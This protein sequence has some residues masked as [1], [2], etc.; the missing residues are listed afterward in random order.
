MNRKIIITILIIAMVLVTAA[1]IAKTDSG[2]KQVAGFL[3]SNILFGYD[4]GTL[5]VLNQQIKLR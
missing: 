3:S 1:G 4:D 2:T 5:T